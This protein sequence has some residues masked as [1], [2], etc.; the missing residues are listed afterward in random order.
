M[1]KKKF[2]VSDRISEFADMSASEIYEEYEAQL[3]DVFINVDEKVK[4][5]SLVDGLD[6]LIEKLDEGL[7]VG[8]PMNDLPMLTKEIGGARLGEILLIGGTSGTGKSTLVRNTIIPSSVTFEEEVVFM[9]NEENLKK[10]L[11]L[12]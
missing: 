11:I 3:N 1:L 6:E 7:D 2:P 9:L 5:Y 12:S 4:T 10:F 8:L